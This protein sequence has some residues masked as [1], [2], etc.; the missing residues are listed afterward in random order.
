MFPA[1]VV[2]RHA[3]SRV[4]KPQAIPR[5]ETARSGTALADAEIRHASTTSCHHVSDVL[6]HRL[7][8][9][10]PLARQPTGAP[11]AGPPR[12]WIGAPNG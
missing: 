5:N 9:R 3:Q 10:H 1:D 2:E 11:L 12:S 6:V 4:T 7:P 8:D